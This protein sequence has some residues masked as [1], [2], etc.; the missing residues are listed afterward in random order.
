MHMYTKYQLIW[1]NKSTSESGLPVFFS[2]DEMQDRQS[3]SHNHSAVDIT[4]PK[5]YLAL[6]YTQGPHRPPWSKQ[7][8]DGSLLWW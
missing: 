3:T 7:V 4:P 6:T 5:S 2:W 8:R 1:T